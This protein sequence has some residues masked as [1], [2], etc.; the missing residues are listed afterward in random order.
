LPD[1]AT[2]TITLNINGK[3]YDFDVVNGVANVKVPDL[4][5]GDYT[6]AISYSGDDKYASFTRIGS[7]DVNKIIPT[8]LT[9][10]QIT[11]VYNGGKYL[12]IT[13]KDISGNVIKGNLVTI[14]LNGK[15]LSQATDSNGQVKFSTNGL[16]PKIYTAS[17]TFA[18]NGNYAKSSTTAKVTVTKATPKITAKAK[19]FKKSVKTKKYTI[20]LKDNK[21]KVM[22]KA[23]VTI[24]IKGKTYK[25]TTNSKGKATF[26]ITKL[27]KKGTFKSVI[28]YKGNSYYKNVT[29]KV[30]IKV[31]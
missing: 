17:V 16:T 21:G 22:K 24:K 6:Y 28:S 12:I 11:T 13:L 9:A 7:L 3:S 27:T 23:K 10:A 29:K 31:K 19:T 18:G 4:S 26:K 8:Q 1:D 30:K 20:T 15:L 2:G 25:A 14:N 5:N